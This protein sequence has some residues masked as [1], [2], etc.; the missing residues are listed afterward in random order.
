MTLPKDTLILP[1]HFDQDLKIGEL[2]TSTV[3]KIKKGNTL[4]NYQKEDF[5]RRVV[6][7]DNADSSK[8]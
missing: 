2:V 4:L 1:G 8:L 7:K 3:E 5:V 6:S